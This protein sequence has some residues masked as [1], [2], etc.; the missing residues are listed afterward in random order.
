MLGILFLILPN[1]A[2]LLLDCQIN[3][4][5]PVFALRDL[6]Y[7]I[8]PDITAISD[9]LYGMPLEVY[10]AAAMLFWILLAFFAVDWDLLRD[11]KGIRLVYG[12]G[13]A[14][15][16]FITGYQVQD[17]GSVLLMA[18]HPDSVIMEKAKYNM[19]EGGQRKES[20]IYR[21]RL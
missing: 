15:V 1:T 2:N 12:I 11:K 6:I 14:A 17:K 3:F 4:H 13:M 18:D 7:L 5:I 20:S 21:V 8:P 10:R 16:I 9:A 19:D